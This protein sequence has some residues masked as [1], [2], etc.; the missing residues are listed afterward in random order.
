MEG[1]FVIVDGK[2]YRIQ[3]NFLIPVKDSHESHSSDQH[4][5]NLD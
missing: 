1:E 2:K 4:A 3:D 5:S